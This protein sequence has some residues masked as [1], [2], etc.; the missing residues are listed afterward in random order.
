MKKVFIFLLALLFIG[1]SFGQQASIIPIKRNIETGAYMPSSQ[2]IPAPVNHSPNSTQD[3]N[4]NV[5]VSD[6]YYYT[7][8]ICTPQ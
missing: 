2:G 7:G 4:Y 8:Q 1:N 6:G 5:V 3:I